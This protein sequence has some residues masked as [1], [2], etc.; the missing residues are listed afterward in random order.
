MSSPRD[1]DDT[2]YRWPIWARETFRAAITKRQPP[3]HDEPSMNA[4]SLTISEGFAGPWQAAMALGLIRGYRDIRDI[5]STT[6]QLRIE[7]R[8]NSGS[9]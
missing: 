8:L 4:A 1:S 3:W 9:A 2:R 5:C 7:N 6:P